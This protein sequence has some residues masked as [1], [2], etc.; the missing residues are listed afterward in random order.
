MGKREFLRW[1][2]LVW[3]LLYKFSQLELSVMLFSGCAVRLVPKNDLWLGKLDQK[4]HWIMHSLVWNSWYPLSKKEWC[5]FLQRSNA[6]YLRCDTCDDW[7]SLWQLPKDL[8]NV[9]YEEGRIFIVFHWKRE[10]S[11]SILGKVVLIF[12]EFEQFS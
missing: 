8:L 5:S 7:C 1:N 9:D 6:N 10:N 12:E 4:D 2:L 11:G 3:I